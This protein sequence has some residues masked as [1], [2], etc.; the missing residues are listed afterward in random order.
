MH[1]D[2]K[3]LLHMA[4]ILTNR[5]LN[6]E[7]QEWNNNYYVKMRT[8]SASVLPLQKSDWVLSAIDFH[9]FPKMLQ[10]IQETEEIPEEDLKSIIWHFSSKINNRPFYNNPIPEYQP[11]DYQKDLWKTIEKQMKSI[12]KYAIKNYS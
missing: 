12:A 9:C 10:W 2:T 7:S 11:S 5:F 8:I 1:G 4:F 6:Q 3:M